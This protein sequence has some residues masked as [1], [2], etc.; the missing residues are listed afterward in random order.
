MAKWVG[1]SVAGWLA[2]CV[3]GLVWLRSLAAAS[4]DGARLAGAVLGWVGMCWLE[5]G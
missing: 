2:G 1:G 5:L 3:V 4:L